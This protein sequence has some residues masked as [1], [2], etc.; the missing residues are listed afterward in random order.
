[1]LKEKSQSFYQPVLWTIVGLIFAISV[2]LLTK[3]GIKT[4]ITNT[5]IFFSSCILVHY[6]IIKQK[7]HETAISYIVFGIL[8][9]VIGDFF[10]ELAQF[11]LNIPLWDFMCFYLFGNVGSSG[12]NFYDPNVFL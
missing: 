7:K 3:I 9:F 1:M 8:L 10:Y 12:L 4:S 6:S 5:I 2:Y 11:Y